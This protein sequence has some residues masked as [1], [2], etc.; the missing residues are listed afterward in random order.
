MIQNIFLGRISNEL[1]MKQKQRQAEEQEHLR[2][3]QEALAA[4]RKQKELED[5]KLREEEEIRRR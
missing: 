1:T 4:E 5:L 2:K 3:I